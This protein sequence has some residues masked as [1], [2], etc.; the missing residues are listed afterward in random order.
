MLS[1]FGGATRVEQDAGRSFG[2]LAQEEH[3]G[4]GFS[5]CDEANRFSE[6]TK[7]LHDFVVGSGTCRCR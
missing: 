1:C 7:D 4:A 3:R 6:G 5:G 2:V